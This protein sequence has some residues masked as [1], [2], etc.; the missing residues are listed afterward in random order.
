MPRRVGAALAI[1]VLATLAGLLATGSARAQNFPTKPV[2]LVVPWPAGGPTDRH[3]R[4]LAEIA[5][6]HLGQQ[7]IVDNKPGATGTLGGA[8]MAANAKPDGYTVAQLPLT[9]FRLPYMQKTSWD[10]V[11]DFTFVVH[12]TGYTLGVTSHADNPWKTWKEFIDYAKANPNKIR[13][14]TSG[15]SST[16]HITMEQIALKLGIKWT[17]VPF[18]GDAE[19]GAALLGR[20][21]EVVGT[22]TGLA[23]LIDAGQARM[24]AV[25]TE[26]R[27]PRFPDSPTLLESGLDIVSAS[28]YGIAGPKGMDSK[29]VKILHDAFEKALK[30][31]AHLKMLDDLSQPVMYMNSANYA[32]YAMQQIKEQQEMIA[33]LGLGQK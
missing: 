16:P 32:K 6:K 8:L 4:L 1:T 30:D 3:L 26:K 23:G 19:N 20:H 13:Y 9:I 12:L 29:I 31:P 11:K 27:S 22:G 10:P 2:T 5:G 24:L 15:A 17:H 33:M 28:P 21:V 18:K 14:A 7:V 25:W